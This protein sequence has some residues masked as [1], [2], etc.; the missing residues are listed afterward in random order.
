MI[1]GPI[2]LSSG[3]L[4]GIDELQ[5]WTHDEQGI[6]LGVMEEGGKNRPI[7]AL[8]TILATVNP[9]DIRYV[10]RTSISKGEISILPP[11]LD[12]FDQIFV[13]L[14]KRT[15]AD[16]RAYADAKFI[17]TTQ[18]SSHN[19][20]FITKYLLF[21]KKLQPVFTPEAA[22]MLKEF[23]IGLRAQRLAGNR[24]L[25]TIFRNAEAMAKLRL[26]TVI[27]TAIATVTMESVSRMLEQQGEL[28][29]TTEDPRVV[30]IKAAPDVVENTQAPIV[31]DEILNQV[32]KEYQQVSR[33]C[34]GGSSSQRNAANNR[35]YRELHDRF[36]QYIQQPESKINITSMK[37]LV[38]VWQTSKISAIAVK[39][40]TI[41]TIDI[42]DKKKDPQIAKPIF[43]GN[44]ASM[45]QDLVEIGKQNLSNMSNMSI[46]P[47]YDTSYFDKVNNQCG[48]VSTAANT[49]NTANL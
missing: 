40:S 29:K 33:W 24:T 21:A 32:C 23:W 46:R 49:E 43:K 8:T 3:A 42:F 16:D 11:L 4:V 12:R 31:F 26:R 14:D 39:N 38:V 28:I 35:R 6:L 17:R 5:T 44:T 37:P 30:F 27:D 41:D 47:T 10:N 7:I 9:Q 45:K 20:N 15:E 13:S 34:F 18:R 36:L 2:P 22:S 19:Y 25:E 48:L 1:Y